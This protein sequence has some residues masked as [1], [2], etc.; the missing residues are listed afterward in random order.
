[1]CSR[2]ELRAE[3]GAVVERFGLRGPP[4]WPNAA[5]IRPTDLALAVRGGR[6]K[7]FR[8]GLTVEW[9]PRPLINARA[10]TLDQRPAFRPL[11][12]A[13][14]LVPATAWWEWRANGDGGAKTK[15]RL[16]RADG[17]LFALAGLFDGDRLVVVTCAA[18][19]SVAFVHGRMPVVLAPE[20]EGLWA[21]ASQPFT[22]AASAL[23]P[24]GGGLAAVPEPAAVAPTPR[25]AQGDLFG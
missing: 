22:A 15:M 17:A 1:M 16:A 18:A 10:E 24:Y 3:R 9:D 5:E 6:G 13:R 7:L 23:V 14:V 2:F 12:A 25:P 20:A 21:D 4:P 8:W 19:P 11:L